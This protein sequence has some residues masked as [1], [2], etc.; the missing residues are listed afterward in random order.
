MNDAPE[1]IAVGRFGKTRGVTGEIYIHPLTD[2]PDRFESGVRVWVEDEKG[3][4]EIKF[5]AVREVSGR[6]SARVAGIDSPE[7]ARA[8]LTNLFI[9]VKRTELGDAPEGKYYHF[10]LVG[11]HVEDEDKKVYGWVQEVEEYPANDVLVV[12]TEDEKR[13]LVPMVKQFIVKIDIANRAI[14]IKPDEGLFGE[15]DE[16]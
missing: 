6:V 13:F 16:N 12:M 10:D 5:D 8:E 3:Y 7:Q 15:T 9:Y 2:N 4:R 1:Y 14:V 11:C